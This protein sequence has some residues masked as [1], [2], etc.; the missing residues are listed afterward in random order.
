M[1]VLS[2][3]VVI[4]LMSIRY[5]DSARTSQKVSTTLGLVGDIHEASMSYAK[6]HDFSGLTMSNLTSAGLLSEQ[7]TISP[8]DGQTIVVIGQ[9]TN[10]QVKITVPGV[11]T[12]SCDQLKKYLDKSTRS[13]SESV[14]C[15]GDELV[16]TY[17]LY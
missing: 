15:P 7:Q 14:D 3:L 9:N 12:N 1:L 11:P 16:V 5:F 17:D 13:S 2:V 8:W 10:Q 6:R 4:V